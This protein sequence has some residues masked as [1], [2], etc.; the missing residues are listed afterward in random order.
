MTCD[1]MIA[2]I[3]AYKEGK[4]IQYRHKLDETATWH[5]CQDIYWNFPALVYR[6]KPEP[7]EFWVPSWQ[8]FETKSAA[9][10]YIGIAPD[11][12]VIHVREV[13]E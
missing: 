7:R 12:T 10:S 3:Q 1:E 11:S 8:A 9:L 6:I 13:L 4:T 5:D 2:V